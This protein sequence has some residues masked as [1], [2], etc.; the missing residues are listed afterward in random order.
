MSEHDYIRQLDR[1]LTK[2]PDFPDAEKLVKGYTIINAIVVKQGLLGALENVGAITAKDDRE[3]ITQT[4]FYRQ[5]GRDK[6]GLYNRR[7]QLSNSFHKCKSD[8]ERADV[9]DRIQ[10]VQS[11]IE[12][13]Q[14]FMRDVRYQHI[15]LASAMD[16]YNDGD[17]TAPKEDIKD[18]MRDL[19]DIDLI[20][21]R[22]VI[23]TRIS[24]LKRKLEVLAKKPL[25]HPDRKR[26]PGL[27]ADLRQ[28]KIDLEY[29][30]RSISERQDARKAALH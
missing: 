10:D 21:K 30:N 8:E 5:L 19:S 15:T 2:Y 1:F 12:A 6:A 27:E 4:P 13:L 26:I 18:T 7:A 3:E 17:T 29:A 20:K 11:R 14:R 25:D 28:R 24:Q 23:R 9:S 16:R 22:Q